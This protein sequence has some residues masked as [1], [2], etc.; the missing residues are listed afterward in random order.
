ML[1][2]DTAKVSTL[3]SAQGTQSSINSRHSWDHTLF[4][5]AGLGHVS[6]KKDLFTGHC[7]RR[8]SDGAWVRDPP[9]R[10]HK[11]A[12]VRHGTA[13]VAP[14]NVNL[15][16]KDGGT[17]IHFTVII[18]HAVVTKQL[19]ATHCNVNLQTKKGETPIRWSTVEGNETV[20]ELLIAA[21]RNV[22]LQSKDGFTP[23][24]VPY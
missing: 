21:H 16:E 18:G 14:C 20:T 17:T 7:K 13:I 6:V 23:I 2:D 8:P 9:P 12:R 15:Q 11:R 10:G 5:V 4:C 24:R 22:Y 1:D 3:L 19:I